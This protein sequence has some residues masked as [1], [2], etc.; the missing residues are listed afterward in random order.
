MEL[1]EFLFYIGG[2]TRGS[3]KMSPHAEKSRS[4]STTSPVSAVAALAQRKS[5][6]D[7]HAE[8]EAKCV[9]STR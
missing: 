9:Y 3:V 7:V 6:I 2:S 1:P 8:M 5:D 4:S